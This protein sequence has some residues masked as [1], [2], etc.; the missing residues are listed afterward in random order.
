MTLTGYDYSVLAPPL[1]N[2]TFADNT[3][4]EYFSPGDVAQGSVISTDLS[5]SDFDGLSL[6]QSNDATTALVSSFTIDFGNTGI[7]V[8]PRCSGITLVSMGLLRPMLEILLLLSIQ[9]T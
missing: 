4:L 8:M 3:D 9:A 5:D 7:P 6:V 1:K 2:L